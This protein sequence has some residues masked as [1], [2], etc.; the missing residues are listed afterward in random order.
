MPSAT[1]AVPKAQRWGVPWGNAFTGRTFLHPA[2]DY[3][4][5]GGG[6]SLVLVVPLLYFG[7]NEARWLNS[8]MPLMYLLLNA[9]HF[10]AST[11][12][13]YTKKGSF[14]KL[15]FLTR[16]LPLV[17]IGV[18]LVGLAWP[19]SAGYYINKLYLTWSPFHYAATAY[20]LAL[21]YAYRSGCEVRPSDRRLLRW[22]SLLPFFFALGLQELGG[23]EGWLLTREF[24]LN[25]PQA[26]GALQQLTFLLAALSFAAPLLLYGRALFRG[27][28]PF[29]LIVLLLL[30]SN[31]IWWVVFTSYTNAFNL[32]TMFHGFQYLAI[33]SI[34]HVK[35]RLS[36]SGNTRGGL[37]HAAKFYLICLGLAVVLFQFWPYGFVLL[38]FGKTQSILLVIAI[39]NIHHFIVDAYIWK[40]KSDS[41][42]Y[43]HIAGSAGKS[44]RLRK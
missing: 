42:N 43:S 33:V 2:F 22:G 29:P 18:L 21:I 27:S 37:Y 24:L 34:F 1:V 6:L 12:R 32:A 38:G 31:G 9:A 20:G 16:G 11:V 15:P 35:E 13:L 41:T 25:H 28:K 7:W 36:E 14:E 30:V 44:A 5:I 40:L 10:A 19:A 3:L 4:V 17:T 39:I 26:G 23:V 8:S